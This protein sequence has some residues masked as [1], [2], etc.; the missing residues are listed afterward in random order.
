MYDGGIAGR[1][2]PNGAVSVRV[3]SG[4]ASAGGSGRLNQSSGRGNW[5]GH[6]GGDR[7]SGYWTAQRRG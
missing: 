1:V 5:R 3:T 4:G 2:A 7:C 6:S